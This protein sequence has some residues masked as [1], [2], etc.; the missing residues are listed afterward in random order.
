MTLP[1]SVFQR[2]HA[3]RSQLALVLFLPAPV[4]LSSYICSPPAVG[5]TCTGWQQRIAAGLH[6]LAGE[7]SRARR[8]LILPRCRTTDESAAGAVFFAAPRAAHP[9]GAHEEHRR[10]AESWCGVAT[11]CRIEA[12]VLSRQA[13][14][15]WRRRCDLCDSSMMLDVR[16]DASQL[17]VRRRRPLQAQTAR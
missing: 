10:V 5:T 12:R 17:A 4:T 8:V 16:L 6:A 1:S 11:T 2:T 13:R 15:H 14:R 9:G 3:Y 7:I